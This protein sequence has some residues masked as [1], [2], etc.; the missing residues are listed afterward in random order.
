VLAA[1]EG[2]G[3][4]LGTLGAR[5]D[6]LDGVEVV[7]GGVCGGAQR[8]RARPVPAARCRGGKARAARLAGGSPL[9]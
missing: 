3:R 4:G 1:G 2:R 7:G 6:G 5:F 8:R 9:L